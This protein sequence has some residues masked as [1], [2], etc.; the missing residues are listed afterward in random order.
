MATPTQRRS[1]R[2]GWAVVAVA[3][4]V[5]F[6]GR[7]LLARSV[8]SPFIFQDEGG[9]VGV[10]RLLAGDAPALYGPTYLPGWGVL[11]A[12]AAAVLD[13][14]ALQN[15]AQGLNAAAAAAVIPV[16]HLL[17]T[18]LAKL[19]PMMSAVAAVT[20]GSMAA[21]I[22]QA[23]M[24]LPEALLVLVVAVGV[25]AVHRALEAATWPWALVAGA[26]VGA[27]YAV[28]PRS[29]VA[30]AAL[31][32][33]AALAWRTRVVRAAIAGV[34]GAGAVAVVMVTQVAHELATERLYPAGTQPSL[35]GS[36]FG[37]LAEPIG[38]TV[39]ALGQSWYLVVATLGLVPLGL[40][41]AGRTGW[42]EWTS[43]RGVTMAF[44]AL[45]AL[46]S[47]ALGTIGSYEVGLGTDVTRADLP[48][49]GR[50]L[51]Q[52]VPVLIVLAPSLRRRWTWPGIAVAA[53]ASAAIGVAL[54]AVYAD[55]VWRQPI[56]WHNI[57]SLR[58]AIEAFGRDHVVATGLAA[59]AA[60]LVLGAVARWRSDGLGWIAPLA[61]VAGLNVFSGV[62]LVQGWA[63]PASEA[64]AARHRL[65]PVLERSDETVWV[66]L[67]EDFHVYWA[68][69][70]QYWHP[71]VEVAYFDRQLPDRAT[72]VLGSTAE[73]P[74]PGATLVGTE[75]DG[76]L[77]LW[78]L[79]R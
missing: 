16:L 9:Y 3:T 14:G 55:E 43:A 63:G 70:T 36:P 29:I 23:T 27:S 5:S 35:A 30:V 4:V 6:V 68:Y 28:H 2:A 69:N 11:L 18:R 39:I 51:E 42:A 37:A 65:G 40:L 60:M 22:L 13:A 71:D 19:R 41:A 34:L 52:W 49:Y 46:G 32:L 24:L 7:L 31:V 74:A 25:L 15:A 21:S 73:P 48:V 1:H 20:G 17:G 76:D 44:V 57:A 79:S 38:A 58:A 67:D 54:D 72:L 61:V 8:V 10:A 47:L 33:V 59:G 50:Y 75:R 53:V 64:W 78:S 56:A 45:G 26:V 77:A 66:D 12:P 62:S